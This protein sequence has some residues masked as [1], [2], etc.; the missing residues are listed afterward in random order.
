MEDIIK[1]FS[2][3]NRDNW[4]GLQYILST[5][6][7]TEADAIF[8]YDGLDKLKYEVLYSVFQQRE[9][10]RKAVEEAVSI[11]IDNLSH[12]RRLAQPKPM[13]DEQRT[14]LIERV[15]I[16]I[17]KYLAMQPRVKTRQPYVGF[18]RLFGEVLANDMF[19]I[20][21]TIWLNYFPTLTPH[22]P[23]EVMIKDYDNP[24][25]IFDSVGGRL[26]NYLL[27]TTETLI[28]ENREQDKF[29][30]VLNQNEEEEPCNNERK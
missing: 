18:T 7:A 2:D 16:N 22:N 11:I 17:S 1:V 20:M 19:D 12:G 6:D 5:T 10:P 25:N 26:V 30:M 14:Q 4:K 21:E 29:N 15:R 13:S 9:E 27:R 23:R 8:E 24:L 3:D 28:F